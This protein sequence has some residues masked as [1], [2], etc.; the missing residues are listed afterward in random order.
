MVRFLS[1]VI[2][3]MLLI[4]ASGVF[5]AQLTADQAFQFSAKV[6]NKNTVQA[7]WKIAPGY[8][9]YKEYLS[10]ATEDGD[11]SGTVLGTI[12]YPKGII[13]H[14]ETLGDMEIYENNI[15]INIPIKEWGKNG[16]KLV[17]NYQGCEGST[18]CYPPI[19]KVIEFKPPI[20]STRELS[21]MSLTG[22]NNLLIGG[23][24]FLILGSFFLFGIFLSLTPCV[25]P[26]IPILVGIILGQKDIKASRAF[27]L[28]ITYVLGVAVTY[29]LAGIITASLGNSVQSLLQNF[30]VIIVCGL[31]FFLL[32]LSLFGLYELQLPSFI[33]NKLN[34]ASNK[35]HGGS[36]V[37]V[38]FMGVIS[39]LV[40]SPCVSA[41]LAGTLLY[42][43]STGNVILGGSA[44]FF[45]AL[46]MGVLLVIAGTT[47]GELFLKA[48]GWMVKVKNLLGIAMLAM[49]IWLI[50]RV[51][52]I[53]LVNFLWAVL[54]LGIAI[55]W[56]A[57]E[58]IGN[59]SGWMR[60]RKVIAFIIL[61]FGIL[62]FFRVLGFGVNNGVIESKDTN[63]I[64]QTSTV[65]IASNMNNN[66]SE[67]GLFTVVTSLSQVDK[68]IDVAT[69]EKKPIMIDF[70][71]DWC[72][73]CKEMDA[74]TFKS[75]DVRHSMKSFIVL[76]AD[77]TKNN[78]ETK[79]LMAKYKVFA[80]PYII[81]LDSK[82]NLISQ[83]TIAGAISSDD[84]LSQL[85]MISSVYSK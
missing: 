10:I 44:L 53:E 16:A 81:F 26:M 2:I 41:P 60:L 77:V 1:K 11:K 66:V 56:G 68:Y 8:H 59:G 79:S 65:K 80:P 57:I 29:T 45:L 42:I 48:G 34:N 40:I 30:W 17:F 82:G 63:S 22:I 71:A 83:A 61:L 35:T 74:G 18:S 4:T 73:A 6:L 51:L 5:A 43:A 36:Y 33:M 38:F 19:T 47:G 7:G 64:S 62:L 23:N 32:S 15:T 28:S 21:S 27:L 12:E 39:S 70:Y 3:F 9:L 76:R 50:S 85:D 46:G 55:Y 52:S 75:L 37:G 24:I 78:V 72:T 69:K 13:D 31:L 20:I 49:A 25:L 58:P 54:L 67:D 84:L 14:S